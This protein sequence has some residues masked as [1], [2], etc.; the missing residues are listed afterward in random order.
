MDGVS[1]GLGEFAESVSG[2]PWILGARGCSL[3][4]PENTISGLKLALAAG[5]DGFSYDVRPCAT[6]EPVL[7]ADERLERTTDGSGILFDCTLPELFHLDA[8][9]WFSKKFV[10]EAVPLMDEV[11]EHFGEE[12]A[13]TIH[14]M[15]LRTTECL[16]EVLSRIG[17]LPRKF[18]L[19]IASRSREAC[20]QIRDAGLNA[21]LIGAA[22][23]L[24]S[25]RFVR[26]ERLGGFATTIGGW[27]ADAGEETWSCERWGLGVDLPEDLVT[28]CRLPLFGFTTREAARALA[29]RALASLVP[30][31]E[32]PPLRAPLLSVEPGGIEGVHSNEN[33]EWAGRW[34]PQFELEN[35]FLFPV[36]VKL[37]LRV[38]RGAF[39]V[40]GLPVEVELEPGE[41]RVIP[42]RLVGGSW[43]P[44]GD[45]VA[46]A[47]V[48]WA[49]GAGRGAGQLLW[50][51]PLV[52]VRAISVEGISRRLN[53]IRESPTDAGASMIVRRHG[54]DLLVSIE[55]AGELEDPHVVVRVGDQTVRGGQ[56]VRVRLP[57]D[58]G[59]GGVAFS[60]GIEGWLERKGQ[61]IRGLRRWAGGLP[62]DA[63]SGEPGR[64]LAL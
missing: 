47:I 45:P 64:I 55:N 59:P 50:E 3:D 44:G 21:V 49:A 30:N 43:S 36:H 34:A 46:I 18:P 57:M 9:A 19:R 35:P 24:D 52:R 33:G 53:L 5:L 51:A 32:R 38:R 8:G 15:E 20:L 26:D 4:A 31:L 37:G 28:A 25:F 39:E 42:A 2:P 14:F 40:E 1:L 10:G 60:C 63:D 27:S 56:G 6:G 22:A 13:E 17:E 29:T 58:I 7:M 12:H 11:L 23:D 61:R 62:Q 16:D 41:A 48:T 54:G